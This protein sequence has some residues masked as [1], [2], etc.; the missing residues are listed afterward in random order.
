MI[1]FLIFIFSC[2]AILII[3]LSI[4]FR[5]VKP[6]SSEKTIS[7]TTFSV[8]IP[9]RNEAEKLPFL[10]KSIEELNYPKGLFEIIFVDDASEDN[11]VAIIKQ[12]LDTIS[13]KS[14]ITRTDIVV[15]KN[16]RT[17]NSPKKDAITSAISI[18]KNNWIVTTDADCLLPK[19]WLQ[20][21]DNFIQENNTKMI[22]APVNYTIKNSFLHRFQLLDFMSMQG[23]TIGGF[24]INFPFMCNG[25]NLTYKKEDFIKLNGFEGNNNIASGDDVFLLEKFIKSDVN[26]VRFLKSKDAVVN[27]FPV[28][29]WND[30]VNQRVRW[31]SKTGNFKSIKVKLIGLL[32]LLINVS[33]LF[34]FFG[35][36]I[37]QSSY[38]LFLIL[39]ASKSL[40]DLF[41][42]L[43]TI[44]FF[45]QEKSFWKSYLLSSF[46]Y[47]FFSVWV[48]FKSVFFK[49][50]WK[51]RRFNK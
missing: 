34:S 31:A 6:F 12:V 26:S 48:I 50:N 46:L 21:L 19:N 10:L 18:A 23:T 51:G 25:A 13:R 3:S 7:K 16:K 35:C 38:T 9:L 36:L 4:G 22:V 33:I 30:L 45:E 29:S 39:F 20:T 24:G 14:E 49:Y 37:K 8:V 40:I 41:L 2:Y 47:P 11:S 32:I 15:I 27:T 28:N 42:F 43:P 44:K 17:S 5:K 1:W